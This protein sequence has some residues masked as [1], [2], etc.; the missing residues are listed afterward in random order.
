MRGGGQPGWKRRLRSS[1]CQPSGM[2]LPLDDKPRTWTDWTKGRNAEMSGAAGADG[3]MVSP[4]TFA[5]LTNRTFRSI[6]LATQVS[7]LGWLMQA[8][9]TSWLIATV[10]TSDLVVALVQ[11]SST[12]PAFILSVSA[13]FSPRIT[14]VAVS[15]S[16]AGAL[17]RPRLRC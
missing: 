8:V 13:G 9:A 1:D 11:A 14:A 2:L 3:E 7:S 5:P 17:W 12:L 10:P 4:A 6:W 16:P 15:C